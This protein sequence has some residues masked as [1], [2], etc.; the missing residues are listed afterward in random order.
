VEGPRRHWRQEVLRPCPDFG[1]QR[2]RLAVLQPL[3][4]H[5]QRGLGL[6]GPYLRLWQQHRCCH[7]LCRH[8][9]RHPVRRSHDLRVH[10]RDHHLVPRDHHYRRRQAHHLGRCPQEQHQRRRSR[11]HHPHHSRR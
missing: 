5:R 7:H 6:Q 9:H 3:R 8:R 2:R 4:H 10:R 1:G 11:A